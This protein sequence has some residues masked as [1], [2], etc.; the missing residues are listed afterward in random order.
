MGK[1]IRPHLEITTKKVFLEFS[2]L[3]IILVFL[4]TSISHIIHG[5]DVFTTKGLYFENVFSNIYKGNFSDI[6]FG[7]D[8][9]KFVIL[10]IAYLN[11]YGMGCEGSLP[12]DKVEI[13]I[14]K[15]ASEEVITN[16]YGIE[17]HI[18]CAEWT[19][20]GTGLHADP[21]MYEAKLA[22]DKLKSG[23]SF[24]SIFHTTAHDNPSDDLKELLK[25]S[26]KA[27]QDMAALFLMNKCDG[28]G[29]QKFAENLRLFAMDNPSIQQVLETENPQVR[30]GPTGDH[31]FRLFMEDLIKDQSR[32]WMSNEFIIGST[33]D[34]H[35]SLRDSKGRPSELSARYGYSDFSGQS[36][37]WVRLTLTN[38]LPD[39]MY[40]FDFPNTCRTPNSR[41][42]DNYVNGF[43]ER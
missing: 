3:R 34:V 11:A 7:R 28:L 23:E 42:A 4:I 36:S 29:L 9:T 37:G 27:E 15:C 1:F 41:I 19:S 24:R 20:V 14:P 33:S 39:C 10:Y 43:Y 26:R 32:R 22:L 38:G 21:K 13:A 40:F 31:D 35:V 2:G 5:Q 16:E 17:T 8:N 6:P 18:L 12:P 30:V 25:N